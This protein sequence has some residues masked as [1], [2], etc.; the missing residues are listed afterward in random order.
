MN[1]TELASKVVEGALN[2]DTTIN[3]SFLSSKEFGAD[4]NFWNDNK[5]EGSTS[6]MG[7]FCCCSQESDSA[8]FVSPS[9][10]D[11][12]M[13]EFGLMKVTISRCW[14]NASLVSKI[15]STRFV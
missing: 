15:L 3:L 10:F 1:L 13:L 12:E 9:E 5:G 6:M 14:L 11:N 7:S 2:F 4:C 8:L